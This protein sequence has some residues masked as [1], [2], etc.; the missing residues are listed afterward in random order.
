MVLYIFIFYYT[1]LA[2]NVALIANQN[3]LQKIQVTASGVSY[4][5][6]TT[7][8]YSFQNVYGATSQTLA[9]LQSLG[10]LIDGYNGSP[11]YSNVAYNNS[12]TWISFA[13]CGVASLAVILLL[14]AIQIN[15]FDEIRALNFRQNG[16]GK[17]NFTNFVLIN[18]IWQTLVAGHY[19]FFNFIYYG[20]TEPC[21]GFQNGV[22]YGSSDALFQPGST[23]SNVYMA[24][25]ISQIIFTIIFMIV[26]GCNESFNYNKIL[27]PIT[28]FGGGY[29]IFVL[30]VRFGAILKT[31]YYPS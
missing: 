5:I 14:K 20:Q 7:N 22:E 18:L 28:V 13:I 6:T 21:L 29:F 3:L 19:F 31:Y 24:V 27:N 9:N 2:N 10:C 30:I 12:T 1:Y 16:K 8:Y 4:N 17:F 23:F 25:F 26:M 11:T 15:F